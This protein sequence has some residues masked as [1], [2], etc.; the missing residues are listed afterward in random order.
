MNRILIGMLTYNRLSFTKKSLNSLFNNTNEPFDLTILDNGSEDETQVYLLDFL[1]SDLVVN[2]KNNVTLIL[3]Y[4]NIGV[5]KG[6]NTILSLRKPEQYFM[7]L[8][9]DMVFDENTDKKWLTRILDFFDKDMRIK[10]NNEDFQIGSIC[11]KPFALLKEFEQ[12]IQI[13]DFLFEFNPE[14]VLGCSTIYNKRS[15][16]KIGKFTDDLGLYG[17][18]DSLENTRM[19][20]AK[21]ITLFHTEVKI[22]HIDPGGDTDYLK[23]KHQL[24]RENFQK[25]K[26]IYESL[27]SGERSYFI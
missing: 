3:K 4:D 19:F 15:L 17:Y 25:Y 10:V 8:D 13:E 22:L 24:A 26:E 6:M 1:K 27:M 5:A 16:E 12:K 2:S 23:W 9:N 20:L 11:L 7:K 18:E 14:G 21:F